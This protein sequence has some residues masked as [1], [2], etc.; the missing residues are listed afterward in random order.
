MRLKVLVVVAVI[1]SILCL[2]GTTRLYLPPAAPTN[3]TVK[4]LTFLRSAIDGGADHDAQAMFPEG[5]F[6]LNALY[7]LAWIQVGMT[8]SARSG[9]ALREARWALGRLDSPEG[10]AAFDPGLR[11][12]YGV[13][14]AGWTNWLRGGVLALQT[15]GSRDPAEARRFSAASAEL[16][17]AFDSSETPYLQAYPGQ[18]WPVDSTVAMA[19]LRLHDR[20]LAPR[21]ESTGSRWVTAVKA[22]LDPSTGLMPHRV[23][24]DGSPLSGARATSQSIIHRFLLEID[25]A[26]GRD[27]YIRFRERFIR[28]PL[29]FG[30]AVRE[31]P[32]GVDGSGDVDSGPLV[33]GISL[34]ASVVTL[35]AARLYQDPLADALAGEGELIGVPVSGLHTKRYAFGVLPIADAFLVWSATARPWVVPPQGVVDRGVAWWWQLPWLGLLLLLPLVLW[36]LVLRGYSRRTGST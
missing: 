35:G 34:S 9:D 13:F 18:S 3:G 11:P 14:H 36:L 28:Y 33:L 30:P 10:T 1:A 4:Q 16:A 6:F 15:P 23:A 5:Y 27:Q 20:L 29:G 12:R 26:F 21:F 31:Y 19:S 17:T 7:G 32:A 22:R 24:L 2:V 8:D 25:P